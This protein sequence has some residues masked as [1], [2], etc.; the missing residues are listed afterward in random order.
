M[1]VHLYTSHFFMCSQAPYD[2]TSGEYRADL[3]P[4]LRAE[5]N[6]LCR[7]GSAKTQLLSRVLFEFVLLKLNRAATSQT[8]SN[9][10]IP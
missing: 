3:Y 2:D 7:Y 9:A 1:P 8:P 10:E 5:V 6:D 4:D